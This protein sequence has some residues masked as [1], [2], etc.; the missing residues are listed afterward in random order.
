VL[1][2][3]GPYVYELPTHHCPFCLLQKE[4]R[5][6]GYPLYAAL[7]TAGVSGLGVGVLMPFKTTASLAGVIPALQKNLAMLSIL[8]Y[9][10]FS[11]IVLYRIFVSHL[12]L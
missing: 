10:L 11:A 8:F 12:V 4:Y 1:S 9:A 6:V 2:F 7:L 3:I 5:Y